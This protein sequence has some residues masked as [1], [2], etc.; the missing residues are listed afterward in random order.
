M[1][2]KNLMLSLC[3]STT[4]LVLGSSNVFA[5]NILNKTNHVSINEYDMYKKI[6][7]QNNVTPTQT[8]S[9]VKKYI[10]S[11]ENLGKKDYEELKNLGYSDSKINLLK[12]ASNSN[13]NEAE[14]KSI[15]SELSFYATLDTFDYDKSFNLNPLQPQGQGPQS[16]VFK[17]AIELNYDWSWSQ[18][19]IVTNTDGIAFNWYT[20]CNDK[21]QLYNTTDSVDYYDKPGIDGF[22]SA[23]PCSDAAKNNL[24]SAQ[25]GLYITF[26]MYNKAKNLYALSGSSYN[27]L[28]NP[29]A[30]ISDFYTN[31][32]Y[33]QSTS[34]STPEFVVNSNSIQVNSAANLMPLNYHFT[35]ND[36]WY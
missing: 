20:T 34:A 12:K 26:P 28:V 15:G 17:T 5:K 22:K 33:A 16:P 35:P 7:T 6:D 32:V 2:L 19:P 9:M 14:L 36:A 27:I 13:L 4:I 3:I 23:Y 29:S 30:K 10:Q 11:A 21:L 18:I 1:K 25:N 31:G 8:N 24:N